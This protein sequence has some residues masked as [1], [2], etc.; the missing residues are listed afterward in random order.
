M[1]GPP[2]VPL[3]RFP[4]ALGTGTEERIPSLALVGRPKRIA[5]LTHQRIGR[6]GEREL[7]RPEE[8]H[9]R[10]DH[11]NG[12]RAAIL[13]AATGAGGYRQHPYGTGGGGGFLP[14][15]AA[16]IRPPL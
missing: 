2:P 10:G 16:R 11:R 6:E 5:R 1:S 4:C 14:P 15:G 12:E 3:G 9:A 13:A 8:A 7:V